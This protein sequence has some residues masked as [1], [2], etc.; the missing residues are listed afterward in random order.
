MNRTGANEETGMKRD[1]D[2][3][4]GP[5]QAEDVDA[6]AGPKVGPPEMAQ[7]LRSRRDYGASRRD[8]APADGWVTRAQVAEVCPLCAEK[9]A[10][11]GIERVRESRFKEAVVM[12]RKDVERASRIAARVEASTLAGTARKM[13][14]DWM[15][16]RWTTAEDTWRAEA[17]RNLK[18]VSSKESGGEEAVYVFKTKID[19]GEGYEPREAVSTFTVRISEEQD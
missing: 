14:E 1:A 5:M 16:W 15:D 3:L 8:A 17:K 11:A 13:A 2:S 12:A 6:E 18:L 7:P 9:M 19:M 10:K 4:I